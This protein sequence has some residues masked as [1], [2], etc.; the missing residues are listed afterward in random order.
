MK[1]KANFFE[2]IN[3]TDKLLAKWIRMKRK[4]IKNCQ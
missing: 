2:K 3:K 4:K 1:P